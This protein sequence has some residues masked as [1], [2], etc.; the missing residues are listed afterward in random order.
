MYARVFATRSL[1]PQ[2]STPV[3]ML[4]SEPLTDTVFE[5]AIMPGERLASVLGGLIGTGLGAGM[6]SM[7]FIAGILGIIVGLNGYAFP[8][9]RNIEEILP[10]YQAKT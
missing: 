9:V 8:M 7:F 5:P 3:S 10:D 1:I 2:I 6:K 4:L